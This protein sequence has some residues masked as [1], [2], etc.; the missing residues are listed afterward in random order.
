MQF[1]NDGRSHGLLILH[2]NGT[3]CYNRAIVFECGNAVHHGGAN[4]LRTYQVDEILLPTLDC[5]VVD[6]IATH[7]RSKD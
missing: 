5:G 7:C 6:G 2:D 1:Y 4:N 3:I